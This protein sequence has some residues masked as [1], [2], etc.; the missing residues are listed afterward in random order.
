[1]LNL[2][3]EGH[4]QERVLAGVGFLAS[5]AT[6]CPRCWSSTPRRSAP[7]TAS[8]SCSFYSA[9]GCG[10]PLQT[11]RKHRVLCV[12]PFAFVGSKNPYA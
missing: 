5:T 2:L 7:A 3:P 8:S 11:L 6:R 1:M 4:L 9:Y 10:S 12:P